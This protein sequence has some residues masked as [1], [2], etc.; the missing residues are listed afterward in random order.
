MEEKKSGDYTPL[1][2][3]GLLTGVIRKQNLDLLNKIAD[4]MKLNSIRREELI[5]QFH[6]V[7]Y[8]T[9]RVI[10]SKKRE[11]IQNLFA[12]NTRK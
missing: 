9:P 6:K 3:Y 2:T 11:K 12:R 7:N 8:Y 5:D 1:R 10:V 4:V